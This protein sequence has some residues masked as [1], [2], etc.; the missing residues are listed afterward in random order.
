MKFRTEITCKKASQ[1]IDYSS[2]VVLLGSCFSDHMVDKF[3]HFKFNHF[4]NPFG[5]L[6]NPFAIEKA[7]EQCVS[8]S[9]YTKDQLI[10]EGGSWL[11]LD[12]HSQFNNSDQDT[13]LTRINHQIKLG[14][15]ALKNASHVIITLGTA[16]VYQWQENGQTVGN[17][18]KISQKKFSKRM[19]SAEEASTSL[20]AMIQQIRSV[21]NEVN[22]IFTLSPVRH[23]KDGFM[24]N[25][26]S[27]AVLLQAIHQ[28]VTEATVSYFPAY[29]IMLDDLR[30]YRF[31]KDD[32][33]HPNEVAVNYIW[34]LFKSCWLDE[35]SQELMAEIDEIQ[36]SLAHRPFDPDSKAHKRFI[37]KLDEKIARL[38]SKHPQIK[39]H[40]KRK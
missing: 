8:A 2:Q 13:V 28:T 12:H 11:S 38:Q 15:T 16:W 24:E 37:E 4:S 33:I 14:H 7:I 34:S 23:L 20:S 19:L 31:Y 10:Q 36:K 9:Y 35:S 40:K 26:L 27:K 3:D 29:E 25:A 30:D 5:I 1:Q 17:C 18:H 39:F 21:N 22:F 32:M 6:F